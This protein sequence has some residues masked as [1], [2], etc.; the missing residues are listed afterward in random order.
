V[1]F[2]LLFLVL[3]TVSAA[4]LDT[5]G[6]TLTASST[7]GGNVAGNTIDNN[8][9]TYWQSL[10]ESNEWIRIFFPSQKIVNEVRLSSE[11][12]ASNGTFEASND[13]STWIRLVGFQFSGFE[14]PFEWQNLT[15]ANTNAYSYYR[16]NYT[17]GDWGHKS[18]LQEWEFYGT[19]AGPAPQGGFSYNSVPFW[20]Y[21]TKYLAY[22]LCIA[23]LGLFVLKKRI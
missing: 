15:F 23:C 5:S 22:G 10:T 7:N 18:K 11:G 6:T 12:A 1:L 17:R 9:V 8:R 3:Y 20:D 21:S 19:D 4:K 13:G 2:G 16:L 14:D